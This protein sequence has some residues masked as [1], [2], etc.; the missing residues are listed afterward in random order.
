MQMQPCLIHIS[1]VFHI[2]L[3]GTRE[4]GLPSLGSNPRLFSHMAL[5]KKYTR[6]SILFKKFTRRNKEMKFGQLTVH[7][8]LL[9][10][11]TLCL[12]LR[13]ETITYAKWNI[14]V[15]S[16]SFFFFLFLFLFQLLPENFAKYPFETY[17]CFI[18]DD[19]ELSCLNDEKK[20]LL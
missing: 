10:F 18:F 14:N 5:T 8:L 13:L 17:D 1:F 11:I 20:K 16:S 15:F 7:I 6:N 19:C 9:S 4:M 12:A 2:N 3:F